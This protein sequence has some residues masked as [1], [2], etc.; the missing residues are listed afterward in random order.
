MWLHATTQDVLEF[1]VLWISDVQLRDESTQT[2][3]LKVGFILTVSLSLELGGRVVALSH[4][5]L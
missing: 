5:H 2:E 4:C 1:G 3:A